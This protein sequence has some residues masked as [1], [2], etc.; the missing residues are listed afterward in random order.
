VSHLP[1]HSRSPLT[2]AAQA[3]NCILR[4][5]PKAG[6]IKNGRGKKLKKEQVERMVMLLEAGL[7][8]TLP[9]SAEQDASRAASKT[10]AVSGR[11]GVE[12]LDADGCCVLCSGSGADMFCTF[13]CPPVS[14]EADADASDCVSV[15]GCM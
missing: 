2:H 12:I 11:A 7:E 8:T 14:T 9:A 4:C 10:G 3:L 1:L 5:G 15:C 13:P 6:V